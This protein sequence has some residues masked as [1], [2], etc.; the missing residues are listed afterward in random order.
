MSFI[1]LTKEIVG[2]L[3]YL[4]H[5]PATVQGYFRLE[6]PVKELVPRIGQLEYDINGEIGVPD[7]KVQFQGSAI[8]CLIIFLSNKVKNQTKSC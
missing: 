1:A 3:F 6:K 2:C 7:T 8:I 5:F 4:Y